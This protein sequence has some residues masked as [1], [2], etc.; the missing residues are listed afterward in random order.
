MLAGWAM[1]LLHSGPWN[2]HM[3]AAQHQAPCAPK[4]FSM[5]RQSDIRVYLSMSWAGG[6]SP[7]SVRDPADGPA[8]RAL[9]LAVGGLPAQ[10]I[11]T[12]DGCLELYRRRG[13]IYLLRDPTDAGLL[14]FSTGVGLESL[15]LGFANQ[16]RQGLTQVRVRRGWGTAVDWRGW[17]GVQGTGVPGWELRVVRCEQGPGMQVDDAPAVW[18]QH[19]QG[20]GTCA[21][22]DGTHVPQ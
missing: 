16:L 7:T 9:P 3:L 10:Y 8:P 13:A 1:D 4:G 22:C 21:G 14:I 12:I 6:G 2:P 18:C 17:S 20:N 5:L 19:A 15:L 11:S